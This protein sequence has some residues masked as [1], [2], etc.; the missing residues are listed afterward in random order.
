MIFSAQDKPAA[1][2][3]SD[4]IWANWDYISSLLASLLSR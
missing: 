2:A 3:S 4:A 1:V